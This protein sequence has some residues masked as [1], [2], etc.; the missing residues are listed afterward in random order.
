MGGVGG[1]AGEPPVGFEEGP[2]TAWEPPTTS[3]VTAMEH[4]GE[5]VVSGHLNGD[6][7]C[8]KVQA[9]PGWWKCSEWMAAGR[10]FALP[11][12]TITAV[13]VEYPTTY[14]TLGM[15]P[16]G[17][18]P[19]VYSSSR[20]QSWSSRGVSET[21]VYGISRMPYGEQPLI[22]VT[23]TGFYE[24]QGAGTSWLKFTP[25]AERP[26]TAELMPEG[27]FLGKAWV[28]TDQGKL[29]YVPDPANASSESSW[30][31]IGISQPG[32]T[33]VGI[34][35]NP[36]NKDR[37]YVTFRT[38]APSGL[39]LTEDGGKNFLSNIKLP[40]KPNTGAGALSAVSV[41]PQ[42]PDVLYITAFTPEPV[43]LKSRDGGH[44]W[45]RMIP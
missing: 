19:V 6:V 3:P 45:R 2:E 15:S 39:H 24:E 16:D 41:N 31:A 7:Y 33:A 35:V 37:V 23:S 38:L 26:V 1:S 10:T 42:F 25:I 21:S 43:P 5:W 14:A 18:E 22:L 13:H 12:R 34:T 4:Y 20:L 11:A 9:E 40:V 36:A 30:T 28:G 27:S 17:S 8:G 29:Y 44:S 32:A